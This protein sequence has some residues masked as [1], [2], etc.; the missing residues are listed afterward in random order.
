[1]QGRGSSAYEVEEDVCAMSTERKQREQA[2]E[3]D[4]RWDGT[5]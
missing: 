4:V 5:A 1:M 3:S 2:K